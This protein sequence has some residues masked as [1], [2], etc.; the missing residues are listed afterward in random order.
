M[1]EPFYLNSLSF[2]NNFFFDPGKNSRES[3]KTNYKSDF[4]RK[5]LQLLRF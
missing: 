3:E 5:S 2:C 4:E 1:T